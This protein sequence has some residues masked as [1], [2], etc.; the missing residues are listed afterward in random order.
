MPVGYIGSQ[1]GTDVERVAFNT[2][3]GKASPAVYGND[4]QL[5]VVFV[6]G[7]E[8]REL[9]ESMLNSAKQQAYDT[10]LSEAKTNKVEYLDWEAAVV[11]E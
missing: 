3:V 8:E 11:S 4:G 1:L 9:S 2:D 6:T 7:H 5:Y 10:W